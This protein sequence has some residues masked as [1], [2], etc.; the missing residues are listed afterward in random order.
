MPRIVVG[1]DESDGAAQALRWAVR[2]G[3]LRGWPVT[4]VLAWGFLDQHQPIGFEPDY[5]ESDAAATLSRIVADVLG[6]GA[7]AVDTRA[8]CDLP[9]RALLEASAGADLL[10]VGARGLGGFK[11]LLLGSVSQRCL[12][13][14]TVP[15][16]VVRGDGDDPDRQRRVVAAVDGSA[17][18]HRALAWALDEAR[19]RSASLIAVT[20]W[21]PP[22]LTGFPITE[23]VPDTSSLEAASRHL[24][25]TALAASDVTGVEVD[26]VT[27]CSSPASAILQAAD[28]AD[29]VVMGSRGLGGL[30]GALI[31]S[32]TTQVLQHA[33]TTVVVV[34]PVA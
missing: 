10:V 20:A 15:V 3:Q 7:E 18:S 12:Q 26:C 22:Y 13:H 19:A 30:T 25:A 4:A 23:T 16:A 28:G 2:E 1:V 8:V 17:T 14:A 11:G 33:D 6:G 31:G 21:H 29:L 9:V 24:L 5:T 34:P 27:P 32:V